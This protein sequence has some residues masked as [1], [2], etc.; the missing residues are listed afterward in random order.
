M[1]SLL[2]SKS[3]LIFNKSPL[4]SFQI[5]SISCQTKSF[6]QL[7]SNT[8]NSKRF[9]QDS[10]N[11]LQSKDLKSS[12]NLHKNFSFTSSFSSKL[13]DHKVVEQIKLTTED[14]QRMDERITERNGKRE[15][16]KKDSPT[17]STKS[18]N[19]SEFGAWKVIKSLGKYVWPKGESDLQRRVLLAFVL[20]IGSKILN[21]QVPILFK[22]I[23]DS[24]SITEPSMLGVIPLAAII[25]YGL[26]RAGAAGFNELRS[27]VFAKVA[28]KAIRRVSTSTFS[29]LHEL[30]LKFH[31][32]R[33]TGA[34]SRIIDRGSRGIN[35]ILTSMVF[36]VIPTAFEIMLVMG[37]LYAKFGIS[38][39]LITGGTMLAYAAYTLAVTSWRTKF[40]KEMNNTENEAASRA[41]DSLLNYETVKYF[42]NEKHETNRYEEVLERFDQASLKSQSSLSLL[43]FGQ[44]LIFT[45][46]LTAMMYMGA[47]GVAAGT[48]TLGDLVM[49]NG[50]LFQLSLPLNFLGMIYREI[51]QSLVDMEALFQLRSKPSAISDSPSAIPLKVSGGRIQ[52]EGVTFGYSQDKNILN[53]LSLVAEGGQKIALVGSS[54]SGKSTILRLL[55]RFYQTSSGTI[56]I[57]GQNIRDVTLESLRRAIGVIPQDTVLFNDTIMY[58]IRY[59]SPNA[60]DEQVF[61]AAKKALIHDSIIAMPNGYETQVGERGLKL[62]GGEKQ[63]VSIARTILKNPSIL[64][65]DEATSAVDSTT[66]GLIHQSLDNLFKGR[67]SIHIAH[68]LSTIIDSDVIF[69]LGSEGVIEKGTHQQLIQKGGAYKKM[70]LKQESE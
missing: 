3:L 21:V 38:Y 26:A 30:D 31:L 5:R 55:Y 45:T 1:Q 70:W 6:S 27:A 63:R 50:L 69:V 53:K 22:N 13:E 29:H 58:N 20:L 12:L 32:S 59:G 43:N 4:K 44:S 65:C 51:K 49:I 62:S 37:I 41:M 28:Q 42:N 16:K 36:N 33:Q 47:N 8:I 15:G 60:T 25:G 56:L 46:S 19:E 17:S 64:F 7:K 35:L 66:E 2:S 67:T 61:E 52:F 48:M 68:R 10:E 11:F 40:R 34:L 18:L 9:G 54:G 24:L 39:S 57:D 23:V 14:V